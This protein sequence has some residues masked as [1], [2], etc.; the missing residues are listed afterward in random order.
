MPKHN[1][2]LSSLSKNFF[3][4]PRLS[5]YVNDALMSSSPI[6]RILNEMLLFLF[7]NF[8]LHS[9]Y[10]LFHSLMSPYRVFNS[11]VNKV[12]TVLS[13]LNICIK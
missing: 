10:L 1:L 3:V 4:I 8:I 11:L 5:Y 13:T 7:Y 2:C 9:K 12:D 6:L